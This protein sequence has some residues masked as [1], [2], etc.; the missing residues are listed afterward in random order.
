MAYHDDLLEQALDLIHKDP[1]RPKQASLRRAV[2]TAYYALFHLLISEAVANWKRASLRSELAR[3]FEHGAMKSA[4][5]RAQ[6]STFPAQSAG[7][8]A[9]LRYVARTF[10]QLQEKRHVADYDSATFWMKTEALQQ[11]VWTQEAFVRWR[12]I[13]SEDI[14]QEYLLSLLVKKRA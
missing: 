6:Q 1:R 9:D 5:N 12:R 11:V 4:S 14:A 3:S 2:S 13:R 10:V 7:A 8:V